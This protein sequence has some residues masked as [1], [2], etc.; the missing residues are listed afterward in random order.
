VFR[1]EL[2]SERNGVSLETF[3]RGEGEGSLYTRK[4]RR[5]TDLRKKK[6]KGRSTNDENARQNGLGV[7]KP[8][9]AKVSYGTNSG[10]TD[11]ARRRSKHDG[12]KNIS[13]SGEVRREENGLP[14]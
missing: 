7:Y 11:K 12:V 2:F 10:K 13:L 9:L 6:G 14:V 8:P 5:P 3:R 1:P 4:E